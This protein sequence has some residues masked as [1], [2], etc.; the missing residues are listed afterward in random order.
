MQ[1]HDNELTHAVLIEVLDYNAKTG[2]FRWKTPKLNSHMKKGDV[3]GCINNQG[4]QIIVINKKLYRAHRLAWFYVHGQWPTQI[5]HVNNIRLD[6]KIVN[7]R[8]A[9]ISQNCCNRKKI[10]GKSIAKGVSRSSP[11]SRTNKYQATI[12]LGSER[13]HLGYFDNEEDA[14]IAYVMASILNHGEFGRAS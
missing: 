12:K 5:D 11:R 2:V 13:V 9:T 14:S 10:N 7:L 1:S 3:A 6:N 8:E 4:Y